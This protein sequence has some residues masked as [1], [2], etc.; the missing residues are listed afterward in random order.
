[1]Q[2]RVKVNTSGGRTLDLPPGYHA[3]A[4]RESGD[5]FA[6]ACRVAAET[7]AGTLVW[8]RRAD[9]AE[10]AVVLEPEQPLVTAR[11]AFFLGMAALCDAIAAHCP[12][13]K[14]VTVSYPD[15]IRFDGGL[16]GGGRLGWPKRADEAAIPDW[17][18]FAAQIRIAFDPGTEPGLA[19]H[20]TALAEEGV[21][22]LGPA[23]LIESFA[24]HFMRLVDL[25]MAGETERAT[26]TY[27]DRLGRPEHGV[28]LSLDAEGNLVRTGEAK[29]TV[30]LL[31]ALAEAG[32]YDR[33]TGMPRLAARL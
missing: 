18:V 20:A 24:R 7:G 9:I 31:P 8:V 19:P 2:G 28:V 29:T 21:D 3:V 23:D 16:V 33:H 11:G 1:M 26:K 22:G 6:H 15:A 12:P 25:W 10:F 4:L 27:L 30:P 14:D 17:L 13:E 5:A 32:W